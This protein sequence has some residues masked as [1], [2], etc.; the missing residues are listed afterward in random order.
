MDDHAG[1][2][3]GQRDA[4]QPDRDLPAD[5]TRPTT[6]PSGRENA[7]KHDQHQRQ[8]ARQNHSRPAQEEQRHGQP[9]SRAHSYSSTDKVS[10][11]G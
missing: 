1:G 8:I 7:G 4:S 9:D 6:P 3:R 10:G 2:Q 5:W 11:N